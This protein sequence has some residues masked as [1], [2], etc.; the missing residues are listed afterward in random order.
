MLF[1]ISTPF[2]ILLLDITLFWDLEEI[3]PIS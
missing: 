1:S 2:E 3:K